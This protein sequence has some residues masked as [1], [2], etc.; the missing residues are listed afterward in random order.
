MV[1]E[2]QGPLAG[3]S[4][5]VTG[6]GS[7][8]GRGIA[9]ALAKAGAAVMAADLMP[10]RGEETVA[11]IRTAG[12]IATAYASDIANP[13]EVQGLI[14]RTVEVYGQVSILVN[15]AGLQYISP[16]EEFP[17][18]MWNRLLA[19]LLTGPF[20]CTKAALPHMRKA[21]WGRII[22]ISSIHGKSASPFKAAYV[23]AKHGLIGLTRATAIETAAAN[24]T[25]NAICPGFV[26][27]PL[28]R[29]QVPDLMRNW[30]V[31][32]ESEALELAIYSKTPQRRLLDAAEIG[33][34][35][36]YLASEAA[37]GI[38]GQAINVDG[39]MVMY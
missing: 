12:G 38:T 15:N 34:L 33:D 11:M 16:I 21:G 2:G 29:N 24:I 13:V 17:L 8:I 4:A 10:E 32:T 31:T 6:A 23:S 5:V 18:D 22:N 30:G 9:L 39:G 28:V 25:A 14:D 7:G 19:V 36:T 1:L 3:R 20:L 27:T 26:D 35:A 37:R